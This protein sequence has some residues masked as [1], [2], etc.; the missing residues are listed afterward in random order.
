VWCVGEQVLL[1]FSNYL[2]SLRTC[3]H[4]VLLVNNAGSLGGVTKAVSALDDLAALRV[5]FELNLVSVVG[6]T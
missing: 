6:L 1:I 4:Q 5:Y 3:T 2:R